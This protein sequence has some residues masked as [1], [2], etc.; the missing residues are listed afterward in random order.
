MKYRQAEK[1]T[2]RRLC[3]KT[4]FQRL[5]EKKAEEE[6][7]SGRECHQRGQHQQSLIRFRFGDNL[8]T[9]QPNKKEH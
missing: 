1:Q 2:D 9:R 7:G 8:I 3:R 4:R 6:Q 5:E